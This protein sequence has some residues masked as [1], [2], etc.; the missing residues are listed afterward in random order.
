VGGCKKWDEVRAVGG[1]HSWDGVLQC[2]PR[3]HVQVVTAESCRIIQL[4]HW[5][6][7]LLLHGCEPVQLVTLR[8]CCLQEDKTHN[9]RMKLYWGVLV[10]LLVGSQFWEAYH[11]WPIAWIWEN[12]TAC[13]KCCYFGSAWKWLTYHKYR[14]EWKIDRI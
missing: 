3:T 4:L 10:L 2:T 5:P 14:T 12:A 7:T 1:P 13:G 8:Y 6:L 9:V 11:K